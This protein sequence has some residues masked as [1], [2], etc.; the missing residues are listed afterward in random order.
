MT[1]PKNLAQSFWF[2]EFMWREPPLTGC[3]P[4]TPVRAVGIDPGA[5]NGDATAVAIIS[6]DKSLMT[7]TLDDV[8]LLAPAV[9]QAVQRLQVE[10]IR[11]A[12][13]KI[14]RAMYMQSMPPNSR[15]HEYELTD[16]EVVVAGKLSNWGAPE[17]VS[18]AECETYKAMLAKQRLAGDISA[19]GMRTG[20]QRLADHHKRYAEAQLQHLK[21]ELRV[22]TR[23]VAA[24][25]GGDWAPENRNVKIN[26]RD[27]RGRR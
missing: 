16:A 13:L 21:D 8:E 14:S 5:P 4:T 3:I 10:M 23:R 2:D 15:P 17:Y 25:A 26:R 24:R 22:V 7:F 27:P 20:M 19:A 9:S 12:E 6:A 1:I 11:Q 18:P